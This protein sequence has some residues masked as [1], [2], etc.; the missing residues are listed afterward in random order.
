M[1]VLK[2]EERGSACGRTRFLEGGAKPSRVV[3]MLS[4]FHR[5]MAETSESL[6]VAE[7]ASGPRAPVASTEC[8]E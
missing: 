4:A 2:A 3:S 1:D 6:W 8:V 5:I 7:L